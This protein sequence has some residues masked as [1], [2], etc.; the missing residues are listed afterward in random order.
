MVVFASEGEPAY[1]LTYTL[2]GKT[3]AGQFEIGGKPYL[4]WTAVRK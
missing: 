2:Q 3:L 4:S 1:R